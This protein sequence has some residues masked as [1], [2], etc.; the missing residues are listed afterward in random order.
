M[1]E[2][3]GYVAFVYF[4]LGFQFALH[5]GLTHLA[6]LKV[7]WQSPRPL[8]DEAVDWFW[9]TLKYKY[10]IVG[11]MALLLVHPIHFIK[12]AKESEI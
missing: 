7:D 2:I 6:M 4:G 10:G 9:F 8:F 3:L 5:M 1:F 12:V 11:L